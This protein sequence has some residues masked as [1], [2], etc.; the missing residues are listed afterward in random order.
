MVTFISYSYIHSLK[1]EL[2]C[3]RGPGDASPRQAV[4]GGTDA[5]RPSVHAPKSLGL[6]S[7]WCKV[8]T[9]RRRSNAKQSEAKRSEARAA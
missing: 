2:R 4:G 8:S 1:V 3:A 5:S 6:A 7:W 9:R